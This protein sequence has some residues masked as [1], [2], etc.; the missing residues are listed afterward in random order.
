MKHQR[1]SIKAPNSLPLFPKCLQY[2][3]STSHMQHSIASRKIIKAGTIR[4]IIFVD[5]DSASARLFSSW[6]LMSACHILVPRTAKANQERF[7]QHIVLEVCSF[8]TWFNS[9]EPFLSLWYIVV[10]FWKSRD[11]PVSD[12]IWRSLASSCSALSGNPHSRLRRLLI[13]WP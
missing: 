3:Q 2:L 9:A 6:T 4:W 10:K 7:Y 1:V 13:N 5:F 11:S 12:Q 8:T